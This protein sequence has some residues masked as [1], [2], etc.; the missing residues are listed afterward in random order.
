MLS[1]HFWLRHTCPE[2]CVRWA[3]PHCWFSRTH[4]IRGS[5]TRQNTGA[6]MAEQRKISSS[7]APLIAVSLDDFKIGVFCCMLPQN[8]LLKRVGKV[9]LAGRMHKNELK[10]T[11]DPSYFRHVTTLCFFGYEA[12]YYTHT[13]QLLKIY[14]WVLPVGS[15]NAT[16][17]NAVSTLFR[18]PYVICCWK[19]TRRSGQCSGSSFSVVQGCV[20]VVYL[21]RTMLWHGV[22]ND[23]SHTQTLPLW[24][25]IAPAYPRHDFENLF[26]ILEV[27][28]TALP[29]DG[30]TQTSLS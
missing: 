23:T 14:S 1:Q 26:V 18:A 11:A 5:R 21:S 17:G 4:S 6:T 20:A 24:V 8:C 29:L 9:H 16:Q 30:T 12:N 25:K 28:K 7:P 10:Q 2:P 13:Q 15:N 22:G 3:W 27:I 19:W